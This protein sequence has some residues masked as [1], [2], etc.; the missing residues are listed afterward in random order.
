MDAA[1][2]IYSATHLDAVPAA[3]YLDAVPT[4]AYLDAHSIAYADFYAYANANS[5]ADAVKSS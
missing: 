5:N 1:A 4:T 3:A 2:Y